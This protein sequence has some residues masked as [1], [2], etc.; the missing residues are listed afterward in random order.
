MRLK[1]HGQNK[2]KPLVLHLGDHDPSGI[3]MSRDIEDRLNEFGGGQIQIKRLA[4]NMNQVQ[5]Y[6]PPPNPAKITDSRAAGYIA[7]HGQESW[8]LDAL[9]PAV[10]AALIRDAVYEVRD[11]DLWEEAV[12]EEDKQKEQ[13]GKVSEQWQTIIDNLE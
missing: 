10:I 3:D 4:L 5:Q 7:V 2:Q 6:D 1:R 11:A 13:L 9:E 8:E 12:T